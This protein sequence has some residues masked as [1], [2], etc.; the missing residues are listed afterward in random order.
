MVGDIVE[1]SGGESSGQLDQHEEGNSGDGRG[2]G[3]GGKL[4]T[5]GVCLHEGVRIVVRVI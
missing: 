4:E 5:H 1:S 2:D 3:Q